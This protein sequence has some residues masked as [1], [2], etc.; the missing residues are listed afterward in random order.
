MPATPHAT[1]DAQ[2]VCEWLLANGG[3]KPIELEKARRLSETDLDT[4]LPRLLTRLGIVSEGELARAWAA[5]LPAPRVELEHL[6]EQLSPLPALSERFLH[7]HQVA[8]VG[9]ND[10]TLLLAQANPADAYPV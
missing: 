1:A 6:P 5:L 7:H 8:P 9:W 3:L 10:Q 4:P 2:Q